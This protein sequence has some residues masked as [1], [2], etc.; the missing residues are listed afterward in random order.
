MRCDKKCVT[1]II[2]VAILFI[3]LIATIIVSV[4]D[5]VPLNASTICFA[6]EFTFLAT[7]RDMISTVQ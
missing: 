5:F 3:R 2:N 6:L 7:L 1:R 4:A